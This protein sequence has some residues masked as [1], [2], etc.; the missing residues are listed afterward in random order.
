MKTRELF[1]RKVIEAIH[2]LPYEEAIVKELVFGCKVKESGTV[3]EKGGW[4][5]QESRISTINYTSLKKNTLYLINGGEIDRTKDY[6]N[7]NGYFDKNYKYEIIGLPITIGRVMQA[8]SNV[9]LPKH[10]IVLPSGNIYLFLS[11]V[12]G[13]PICHWKLTKENGQECTDDDQTDETIEKLLKL[14]NNK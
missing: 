5:G 12:L 14:L 6:L 2:G 4:V 3:Y 11:G 9:P 8:F 13:E 10:L 1:K 7:G